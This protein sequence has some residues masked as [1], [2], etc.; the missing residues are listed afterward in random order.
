MYYMY[1]LYQ[2]RQR[3][4]KLLELVMAVVVFML[5]DAREVFCLKLISLNRIS[6]SVSPC[7]RWRSRIICAFHCKS[8]H[9]FVLYMTAFFFCNYTGCSR[10]QYNK[11]FAPFSR[12]CRLNPYIYTYNIYPNISSYGGGDLTSEHRFSRCAIIIFGVLVGNF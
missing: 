2:C 5:I 11:F 9:T 12:R 3:S 7:T 8:F 1:I 4:T 10:D 6:R